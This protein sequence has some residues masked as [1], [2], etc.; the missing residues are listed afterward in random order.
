MK[1]KSVE[2]AGAIGQIGQAQPEAARGVAQVAFSGRSNVG[3]SSLINRLLGR[4]RTAIARVSQQPGKTQEINFYRVRSDL[5]DFFLVDLPGYG[6]ARVPKEL[7]DRWQPLIHGFLSASKDLVGVVQLI[8]VRTGPT[9]D[10]LR[11]VDYLAELGVPV[12]FALT[13][14]DKLGSTARE[15]AVAKAVR[16]LGIDPDQAI[17]FSAL[18]GDGRE[19][20]LETLSALLFPDAGEGEGGEEGDEDR[21][22]DAGE[23]GG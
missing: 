13:K 4:T 19:E 20:L 6:F 17:A 15:Q 1:I 12:L 5:G 11:S 16:K 3:K 14:S 23:E 18:K 8:D 21:E 22:D 7:R 10:D 2:F 9:Q